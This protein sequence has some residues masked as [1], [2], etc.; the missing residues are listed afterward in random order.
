MQIT[1]TGCR[2]MNHGSPGSMLRRS[3]AKSGDVPQRPEM[4]SMRK[5]WMPPFRVAPALPGSVSTPT[6]QFRRVIGFDW[7]DC[8]DM[9]PVRHWQLKGSSGWGLAAPLSLQAALAEWDHPHPAHT[10]RT[11]RKTRRARADAQNK[12]GSL[13]RRLCTASQMGDPRSFPQ[14]NLEPFLSHKN[15][16]EPA[17]AHE[18]MMPT[19]LRNRSHTHAT[20]PGQN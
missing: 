19:F 15:L 5:A 10:G 18:R 16:L 13:Q 1:P 6:S 8:A 17:A 11:D 12:P 14:A 20:I 3:V 2:R 7:K 4:K 9:R